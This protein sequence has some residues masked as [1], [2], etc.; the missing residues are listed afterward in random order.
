MTHISFFLKKVETQASASKWCIQ[1]FYLFIELKLAKSLTANIQ[2]EA[3]KQGDEH[4]QLA[5]P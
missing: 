4:H 2:T 1:L 5:Q 3:A